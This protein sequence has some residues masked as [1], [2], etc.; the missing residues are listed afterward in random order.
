MAKKRKVE[1]ESRALAKVEGISLKLRDEADQKTYRKALDATNKIADDVRE[2]LKKHSRSSMS[3]AW[4]IGN[5]WKSWF[6]NAKSQFGVITNATI[7]A[8]CSDLDPTEKGR[9]LTG[10][11][12]RYCLKLADNY[13]REHVL[14]LVEQGFTNN[15]FQALLKLE[16]PKDR[17]KWEADAL[18][19][20]LTGDD[21]KKKVKVLSSTPGGI[22]K[23]VK[24]SREKIKKNA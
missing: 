3:M 4:D 24:G 18:S 1:K 9:M 19:R 14:E 13:T 20:R 7:T 15:H 12:F 2:G 11:Y 17:A 8:I 6:Q 23:L 21:L 16:N 10:L 5:I 22:E